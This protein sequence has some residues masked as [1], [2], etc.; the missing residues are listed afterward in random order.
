MASAWSALA[1]RVE[2]IGQTA[3]DVCAPE[4]TIAV[5]EGPLTA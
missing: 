3:G 1:E 2:K 4:N 5:P